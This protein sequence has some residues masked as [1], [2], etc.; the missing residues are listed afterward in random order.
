MAR[1]LKQ[2][3]EVSVGPVGVLECHA[4][5]DG[6]FHPDE[7]KVS[8][9]PVGEYPLYTAPVATQAQPEG[10]P[11]SVG[12]AMESARWRNALVGLCDTD[13]ID[14]PEQ[15]VANV[16]RR[17]VRMG[18]P[19][20]A[21]PVAEVPAGWQ[22]VPV[23]PTD[24]MTIVGQHT[25]YPAANSITE[26]WKAML[27]VAPATPV[28]VEP[29]DDEIID[30]AVE[31]LGIDCDRMPYGVVVFARAILSRYSAAPV[32]PQVSVLE[33]WKLVPIEPTP[34]MNE[35]ADAADLEYSFRYHGSSNGPILQQSGEDHWAAMIAASPA[36]PVAAQAQPS[37]AD[38]EAVFERMPDGA[39]GFLKKWGYIQFARALLDRFS[40][41]AQ[42]EGEAMNALTV[43][44][45]AL[46]ERHYGR[47]PSEVQ[48][49]YDRAWAIVFGVEKAQPVGE[50]PNLQGQQ[51]P[52]SGADHVPDAGKMVD[53]LGDSSEL[54][55]DYDALMLEHIFVCEERDYLR[56]LIEKQD[57]DKVDAERY[58]LLS[59]GQ[60]WSI[61]NGIG[62]ALRADEL[63][64]AIDA[65]RKERQ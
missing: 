56:G 62:D 7:R 27:K 32:A 12:E 50:S 21:E 63:D 64:A 46:R 28:S 17:M 52:V 51:Q 3:A 44:V 29:T 37:D 20:S 53:A 55:T 9:L 47:M 31:P 5:G 6:T 33:G 36:A 26:I 48:D 23:E 61:I 38:I 13:R 54:P 65:A 14:T 35:A 42:R 59:R 15:A 57:A 45:K 1:E 11:G 24:T 10:M 16:K 49:A 41:L 60:H 2:P 30:M 18:T 19:V 34:G 8:M 25:R 39:D 22:L 40:F 43:L 4:S 58:R